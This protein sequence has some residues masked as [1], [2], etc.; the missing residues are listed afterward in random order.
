MQLI[1]P[2][3]KLFGLIYGMSF[4][5]FAFVRIINA[6]FLGAIL[7]TIVIYLIGYLVSRYTLEVF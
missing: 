6:A 5:F 7:L 2:N 1:S 3:K 4:G